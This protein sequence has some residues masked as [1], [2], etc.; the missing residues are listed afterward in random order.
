MEQECA[1]IMWKG[2]VNIS[3]MP[4]HKL[5]YT[6]MLSDGDSKA[7]DNIVEMKVYGDDANVQK[8]ECLTTS[9]NRWVL[10]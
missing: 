7:Y 5:R 2:S 10:H 9:R 1:M 4:Q 3:Y 8:E 6:T